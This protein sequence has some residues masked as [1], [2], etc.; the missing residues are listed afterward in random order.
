[1]AKF[2]ELEISED[3][4]EPQVGSNAESLIHLTKAD[5]VKEDTN[6]V[7]VAAQSET[8]MVIKSV[9]RYDLHITVLLVTTL[10][11]LFVLAISLTSL[12]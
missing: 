3:E 11:F 2:H 8:K 10:L 12:L 1:M 5:Q 6:Q 9:I 4:N 7:K